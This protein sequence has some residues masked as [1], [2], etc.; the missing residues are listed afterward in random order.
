M[1][2]SCRL[3]LLTTGLALS[4]PAV[5]QGQTFAMDG[6]TLGARVSAEELQPFECIRSRWTG[7][8]RECRK[9]KEW[10]QVS[11]ATSLFLDRQDRL[12]LL[13]QKFDNIE[14][15]E[16]SAE[17]VVA[18]HSKRFTVEPRRMVKQVGADKVMVAAWGDLE[19]KDIDIQAR[20]AMIQGR[21]ADELLLMDLINDVEKSALDVLPIYEIKGNKGAIWTFYI[22]SG[23]PGWA[24]ARIISPGA[25]AQ[26]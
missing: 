20:L 18:A 21:Q 9:K 4:A 23:A 11:A 15:S 16:K 10:K 19:L 8:E 6:F 13:S 24:M 22:R 26:H 1:R 14:L 7:A 2:H 12:Q 25:G 17:E 5:A 3:L